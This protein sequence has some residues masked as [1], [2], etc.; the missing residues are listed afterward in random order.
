MGMCTEEATK[1]IIEEKL[2]QFAEKQRLSNIAKM[3]IVLMVTAFGSAV[4]FNNVMLWSMKDSVN[5]IHESTQNRLLDLQKRNRSELLRIIADNTRMI[6][7]NKTWQQVH[8]EYS[9]GSVR[10]FELI[11]NSNTTDIQSI[12]QTKADDR[13]RKSDEE[14]DNRNKEAMRQADLRNNRLVHVSLEN[15][16]DHVMSTLLD[17]CNTMDIRMKKI[18]NDVDDWDEDHQRIHKIVTKHL[19]TLQQ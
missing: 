2:E 7:Q 4:G 12:I 18:E 15:E 9:E 17:K 14:M 6:E 5:E 16:V 11:M 10:R 3:L 19:D 1:R 8:L 13:W